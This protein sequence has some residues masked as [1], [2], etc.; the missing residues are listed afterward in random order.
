MHRIYAMIC[1]DGADEAELNPRRIAPRGCGGGQVDIC[2]R[3]ATEHLLS[4]MPGLSKDSFLEQLRRLV[5]LHHNVVADLATQPTVIWLVHRLDP[6]LTTFTAPA[7]RSHPAQTM[8]S[9]L[10]PPLLLLWV[11]CWPPRL[12]RSRQ[13]QR[14]H[15]RWPSRSS[16]TAWRPRSVHA[17]FTLHMPWLHRYSSGSTTCRLSCVAFVWLRISHG[18]CG[19]LDALACRGYSSYTARHASLHLSSS[20]P[21][22][23][24][25][26]RPAS[27]STS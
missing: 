16:S 21:P 11:S 5:A 26:L 23:F 3:V 15:W 14:V 7:A 4:K 27:R 25:S 12:M 24:P 6:P 19:A 17:W 22:M 1:L 10:M 13:Q 20:P 8:T 2:Q 18:L 9:G